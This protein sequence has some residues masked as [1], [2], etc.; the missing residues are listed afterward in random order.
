MTALRRFS[1]SPA[2]RVQLGLFLLAYLELHD[3]FG[4]L[5]A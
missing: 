4:L 5:H 3:A 2:A 1:P